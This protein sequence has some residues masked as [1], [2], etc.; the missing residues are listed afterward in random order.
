L[1]LICAVI[2][3]TLGWWWTDPVAGLAIAGLA[4]REDSRIWRG[5]DPGQ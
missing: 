1:R 5:S 3:A 4:L 2:V